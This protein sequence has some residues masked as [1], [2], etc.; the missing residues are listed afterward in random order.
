MVARAGL[1]LNPEEV[2]AVELPLSLRVRGPAG[3]VGER[4]VGATAAVGLSAA[5]AELDAAAAAR[6]WLVAL[7]FKPAP[8]PPAEAA[9]LFPPPPLTPLACNDDA[10]ACGLTLEKEEGAAAAALLPTWCCCWWWCD[11]GVAPE[12]AEP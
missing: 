12:A 8:P 11:P 2:V 7:R 10:D 3:D 1:G 9:A 5:D 4:A 6:L